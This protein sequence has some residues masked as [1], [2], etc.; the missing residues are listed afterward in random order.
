M[1]M[2]EEQINQAIARVI[3]STKRKSRQ[4]SLYD[5][6]MDIL[7]L[8]NA[9][10][11]LNEVS[12]VIGISSGMLNQFLSVFKLP[13]SVIEM[14]KNR[15]I[16][17]VSL[18]HN[19]SKLPEKDI[20]NLYDLL[21]EKKISSQELKFLIPFRKHYPNDSII[22]LLDKINASK[23]IK[24]S[25][26]RINSNDTTKT[27][28]ELKNIFNSQVGSENFIDVTKE[29]SLIDIKL[30]KNGEKILRKKARQ[31]SQT[32]QELIINLI[33]S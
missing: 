18:V 5:I 14:V 2:T 13:P 17:S 9:K 27:I 30:T 6:G 28:E 24:V 20:E 29:D 16:D 15:T 33:A 32:L 19:L 1:T 23:N 31:S 12:H 8:K 11:G 7:D 4:Y 22:T 25:V 26:V 21:V 3:L 10:G